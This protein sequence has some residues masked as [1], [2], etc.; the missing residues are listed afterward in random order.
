[1]PA[2]NLEASR[3]PVSQ[4]YQ[5]HW[6]LSVESRN[7]SPHGRWASGRVPWRVRIALAASGVDLCDRAQKEGKRRK[8]REGGVEQPV[9]PKQRLAHIGADAY[10]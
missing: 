6:K 5:F 10:G 9:Q 4:F 3:L 8:H 2:T 1:M 7:G